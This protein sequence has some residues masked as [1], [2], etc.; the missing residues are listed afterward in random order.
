MAPAKGRSAL[1]AALEVAQEPLETRP[2]KSLTAPIGA[3]KSRGKHIG[4][5]FNDDLVEKIALLK[6]RLGL[7][8]SQLIKRAIDELY[9]R[10]IARRAFGD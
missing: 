9:T 2:A 7:D 3:S 8:N 1:L 6:I 10:E 5:Y 4:G